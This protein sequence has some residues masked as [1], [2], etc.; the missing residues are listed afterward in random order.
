MSAVTSGSAPR[1]RVHPATWAV[2]VVLLPLALWDAR[3]AQRDVSLRR[4]A[5][6]QHLEPLPVMAPTASPAARR[7]TGNLQQALA[8]K[9]ESTAQMRARQPS[10]WL[11]ALD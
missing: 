4:Q 3:Q 1:R 9:P 11:P 7:R 5:S 8:A 6:V 2:A 10:A